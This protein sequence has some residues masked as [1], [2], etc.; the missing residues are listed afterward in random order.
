MKKYRLKVE[1]EP[2][3]DGRFLAVCP[4]L[5][6]CHAEG[7]TISDALDNVEDVARVIIELCMEKGL[8]LPAELAGRDA[9]PIVKAEVVVRVGS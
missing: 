6:G 5:Q 1:V 3:E 9:A 4:E 7:D 2:L 8:A